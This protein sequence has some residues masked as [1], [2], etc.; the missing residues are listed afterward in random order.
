MSELKRC[1]CGQIPESLCVDEG[2]A[3]GK[4]AVVSG[5]CCNEWSVEFRTGF[6]DIGSDK[7]IEEAI[8]EWNE[9]KRAF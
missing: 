4:Y 9:A 7:C 6:H 5:N 2:A 8:K 1:P 3:G